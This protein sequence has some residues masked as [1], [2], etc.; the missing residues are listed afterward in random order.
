[1]TLCGCLAILFSSIVETF[2]EYRRIRS[3]KIFYRLSNQYISADWFQL[4]L[5]TKEM[6]SGLFFFWTSCSQRREIPQNTTTMRLQ[7]WTKYFREALVF[8]SCQFVIVN[9]WKVPWN[10]IVFYQNYFVISPGLLYHL[11]RRDTGGLANETF[12]SNPIVS[13]KQ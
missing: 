9:P 8:M 2:P 7:P 10:W 6:F 11:I 5:G 4:V 1:M 13:S 3:K 12:T